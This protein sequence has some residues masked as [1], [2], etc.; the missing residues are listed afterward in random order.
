MGAIN[1][2]NLNELI[3]K[4]N[5][6]YFFE[7]GTLR[8]EGVEYAL[9]SNFKKIFSV[10]IVVKTYNEAVEKFKDNK[11]V[12]II[13]GDSSKI[14]DSIVSQ[15]PGNT[16]FWLDAHFPGADIG[17]TTY[18]SCLDIDYNTRLPLEVE[19]KAIATR[20]NKFKDVI[21]ADDLWLFKDGTYGAGTVD[22]HCS[23]HGH[24]V[25]K[26]E[27]AEGKDLNFANKLFN[28]THNL[29][30]FLPDQGYLVIMPK[31]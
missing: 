21:I 30:E 14:M 1:R 16:L 3:E 9:K 28:K 19:L 7:T 23:A 22:E 2:F 31:K 10:E 20:V 26:L 17:I 12:K 24:N 15:L 29:K 5:L 6:E 18:R 4:Y 13:H 27:L 8:G 25:T 11:K